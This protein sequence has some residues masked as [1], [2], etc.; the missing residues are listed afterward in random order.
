M[1]Q[2]G[3]LKIVGG[4][5]EMKAETQIAQTSIE[6]II[7]LKFKRSKKQIF[8]EYINNIAKF[9]F[10]IIALPFLTLIKIFQIIFRK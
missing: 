9:V 1:T 10:L 8:E 6:R 2:E 4:K 7:N 5:S 3:K